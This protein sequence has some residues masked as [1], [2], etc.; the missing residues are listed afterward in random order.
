MLMCR[1]KGAGTKGEAENTQRGKKFYWTKV[2]DKT[3]DGISG[4][5]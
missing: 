2:P 3:E 1:G 4:H 5:R